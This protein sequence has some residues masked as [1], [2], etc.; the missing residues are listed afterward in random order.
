MWLGDRIRGTVG[1]KEVVLST[2][3]GVDEARY[4]RLVIQKDM[5]E[6]ELIMNLLVIE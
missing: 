4:C 5:V 6:F 2:N 3:G 1:E